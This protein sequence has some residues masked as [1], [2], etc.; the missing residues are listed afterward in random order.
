MT[1]TISE[2]AARHVQKSLAKRGQGVGLRLAVKTS[3]CSGLAYALEFADAAEAEDVSFESHGVTVLVDPKS[4]PFLDGT[5]LDFVREG[6]NEGFKFNNPN[7][8]A[9]CGCGESF[10]V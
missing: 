6:L 7:V 2:A 10:G 4:L 1:I 3:G 9:A 5:E 8:K